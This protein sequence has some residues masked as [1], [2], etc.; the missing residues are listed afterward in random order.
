MMRYMVTHMVADNLLLT[1]NWEL[2]FSIR[3]L[4]SE[5]TLNLKLANSI[6]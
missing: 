3:I 1:S 4:Y 2:R 5:L 6:V